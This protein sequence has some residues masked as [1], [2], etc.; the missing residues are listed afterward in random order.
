MASAIHAAV[1]ATIT[2]GNTSLDGQLMGIDSN[3]FFVTEGE[4]LVG[5]G[6]SNSIICAHC[7]TPIAD[8]VGASLLISA[9]HHGEHHKTLI[10]IKDILKQ[11]E[12]THITVL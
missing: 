5:M 2:A 9:R 1:N 6:Q 3:L 12:Q 8:I 11:I 7:N 4:R 10:P